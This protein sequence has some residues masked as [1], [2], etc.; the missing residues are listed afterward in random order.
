MYTGRSARDR[1]RNYVRKVLSKSTPQGSP[2]VEI[3]KK[4][5]GL[6]DGIGRLLPTEVVGVPHDKGLPGAI[7]RAGLIPEAEEM[8][9]RGLLFADFEAGAVPRRRCGVALQQVTG[10]VGDGK[11]QIW[12]DG[13]AER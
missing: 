1:N 5:N 11:A 2:C 12:R 8:V 10:Q 3:H 13:N 7:E 4:R 9:F 6:V